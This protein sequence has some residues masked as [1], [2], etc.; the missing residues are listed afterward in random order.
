MT[1]FHFFDKQEEEIKFIVFRGLNTLLCELQQGARVG[2]EIR[3]MQ[4]SVFFKTDVYECSVQ[5]R[6]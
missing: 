6:D 2:A 4:E 1:E 3:I 5:T